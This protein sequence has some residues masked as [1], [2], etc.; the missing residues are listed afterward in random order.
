MASVW[1]AGGE[2]LRELA[3]FQGP[4]AGAAA[5]QAGGGGQKL[6]G[7]GGDRAGQAEPAEQVGCPCAARKR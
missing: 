3:Y 6:A 5:A 7:V 1:D 4:F 2:E